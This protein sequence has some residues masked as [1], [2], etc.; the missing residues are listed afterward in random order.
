MV[1]KKATGQY[2]AMKALRKASICVTK[3]DDATKALQTST[4]SPPPSPRRKEKGPKVP[5]AQAIK[6]ER[7][8]L[9]QVRHPFIVQFFYAFQTDV[10]LYLIL[11]YAPGGELFQFMCKQTMVLEDQACFYI[12]EIVMALEHLHG[13]GVIYRDLKPENVLLDAQGSDFLDKVLQHA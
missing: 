9:E 1:K 7:N 8:I 2:Y 10:R 11:E 12:A 3:R 13:L 5:D 4:D 6:T